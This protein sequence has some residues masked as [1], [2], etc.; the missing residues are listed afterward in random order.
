VIRRRLYLEGARVLRRYKARSAIVALGTL[1]GVALVTLVL[2]LASGAQLKIRTTV[3]QIFGGDGILVGAGGTH[4]FGGPRPGAARLTIDDIAAVVDG[5]PGIAAWDPQQARP[6]AAV[7]ARDR[8]ATVRLL[9]QSAASPQ[10]WN[11]PAARG[12]FFDDQDVRTAARVAVI[13]ETAA[14]TLFPGSD[15]IGDTL[16]VD[17]V[18]FQVIGVL[19]R[20][21]TDLHGMDRDNEIVVPITT[22]QRRVMNVDSIVLAKLVVSDPDRAD[23]VVAGVRRVLRERH[24][25][26]PGQPDDFTMLTPRAVREM[27]GTA[28][29]VTS[30]WLPLA[31]LAIVA[32]VAGTT[33]LLMLGSVARRRGEIGLRRAVGATAGDVGLQ[34]TLETAC[35]TGAGGLFGVAAGLAAAIAT[36]RAFH[37]DT[38]DPGLAGFA[39][40]ALSL[41]AG[42]A[43][44]WL[45]ARRA[46]AIDP[47]VAVR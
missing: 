4:L 37:V 24:A 3:R 28:T 31:S 23:G 45:P 19:Q 25:L 9:G 22:L 35:M 2:A 6:S 38:L 42:L 36:A 27:V 29:R 41:A 47:A 26:Q 11:R 18:P 21:G 17:A 43:A 10:V 39:G 8:S 30:T 1:V 5:V 20:F 13:G 16:L 33:A 15:A 40:L 7:K 12:R 44:G 14:A 32:V 46:A 34:F